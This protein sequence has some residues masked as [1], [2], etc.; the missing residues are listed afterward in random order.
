VDVNERAKNEAAVVE[1]SMR[2]ELIITTNRTPTPRR[3]WTK[4]AERALTVDGWSAKFSLT[5]AN[6]NL[7]RLKVIRKKSML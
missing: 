1:R 3:E 4:M 7:I 5:S 6:N 2:L